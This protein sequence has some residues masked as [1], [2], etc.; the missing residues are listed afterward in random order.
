MYVLD[1]R[2]CD[3]CFSFGG[4]GQCRSPSH[5]DGLD[6]GEDDE[7]LVA[8]SRGLTGERDSEVP[9]TRHHTEHFSTGFMGEPFGQWKTRENSS[10]WDT[11]PITLQCERTQD[12]TVCQDA[13][14][15]GARNELKEYFLT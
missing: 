14:S 12:D 4:D 8:M 9:M 10:N 2:S 11:L 7:G 15:D 3:Q 6:E 1:E 5:P 13:F